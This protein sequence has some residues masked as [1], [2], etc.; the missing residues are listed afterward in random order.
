LVSFW[1]LVT[2]KPTDN[3]KKDDKQTLISKEE[4]PKVVAVTPEKSF[5][6]EMLTPP[7]LCANLSIYIYFTSFKLVQEWAIKFCQAKGLSWDEGA[8]IIYIL[9]LT[10][11]IGR[12]GSG[13]LAMYLNIFWL[14]IIA[15][16]IASL[17]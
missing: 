13:F 6:Q 7:V 17:S 4:K 10:S 15:L 16:A 1:L 9:G 8:Y 5:I 14:M 11:I 2:E 12:I 3:S